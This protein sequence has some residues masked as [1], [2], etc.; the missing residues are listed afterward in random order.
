MYIEMREKRNKCSICSFFLPITVA[1]PGY[2]ACFSAPIPTTPLCS[3]YQTYF[4][5]SHTHYS[6]LLWV[7]DLLFTL[8]YPLQHSSLG[9]TLA[10]SLPYPL[11]HSSLGITLTF[12]A[13]IPTTPFFSG[14]HACFFLSHTH[15]DLL[16]WVSDLLYATGKK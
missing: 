2:Y 15:A 6:L 11:Q 5:H 10:F 3:G 7:S 16:D 1:L 14:Y 9:I 8:S 13:L 12:S 4:S